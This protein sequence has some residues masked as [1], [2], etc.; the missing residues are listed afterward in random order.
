MCMKLKNFKDLLQ[1]K[2]GK[3]R[4]AKI[5]WQV[6]L[7]IRALRARAQRKMPR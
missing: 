7:E 3:K 6:E 1:Q 5:E 2:L 4:I